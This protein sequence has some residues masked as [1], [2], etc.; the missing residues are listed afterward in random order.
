MSNSTQA[1]DSLK[2]LAGKMKAII[3]VADH[4]EKI[5]KIEGAE[6]E[7]IQRADKANKDADAAAAKLLDVSRNIEQAE[8]RF[9]LAVKSA[10]SIV[11]EATA[12]GEKIIASA[13]A[14]S[15]EIKS[16]AELMKNKLVSDG[17]DGQAAIARVQEE[18]AAKR[19]ELDN[20][21]SEVAGLKAKLS[22][23]IRG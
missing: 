5:G 9:N 20:V 18:I 22:S 3:E 16:A 12:K 23:F 14:A 11:D 7:A 6:R 17:K 8:A 21:R 15:H 19:V 13:N 2:L 4:L 1:A 10:K